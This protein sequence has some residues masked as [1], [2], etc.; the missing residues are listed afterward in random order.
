MKLLT[1]SFLLLLGISVQ[2]SQFSLYNYQVFNEDQEAFCYYYNTNND[3]IKLV[4]RHL[5]LTLYKVN[6][7]AKFFAT[8]VINQSSM[9]L[10]DEEIKKMK[11]IKTWQR[12]AHVNHQRSIP[13]GKLTKGVYIVEGIMNGEVSRIP[14]IVTNYSIITK[15]LSD[16]LIGFVT[17]N[18]SGKEQMGFQFVAYQNEKIVRPSA[19][20]G[21]VV[22]FG[23]PPE[24]RSNYNYPV[25]TVR[26]DDLAVS[27][28]Y[29]YQYYSQE[30]TQFVQY[31]FTDRSAYRPEQLVKFKGILRKKRGY[32]YSVSQDSVYYSIN[33]P[34]GNEVFQGKAKLD[35][36]GS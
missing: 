22:K 4:K 5:Q 34:Q 24:L 1:L 14:V 11:F 15:S 28:G 16:N 7:P 18:Q 23:I 27:S 2:A 8:Q 25:I 36:D 21:S 30:T 3:G 13:L 26:G 19:I 32:K 10:K 12:S 33:G 35:R 6:N 17:D 9:K 20:N 29:Y 31:V